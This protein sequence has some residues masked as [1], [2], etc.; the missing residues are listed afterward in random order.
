M[1][2]TV[3]RPRL[4][5]QLLLPWNH[6]QGTGASPTGRPVFSARE[7]GADGGLGARYQR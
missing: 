3:S 2:G 1:S 4:N 7:T 5:L 6:H